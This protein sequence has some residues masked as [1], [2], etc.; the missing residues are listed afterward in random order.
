MVTRKGLSE[1]AAAGRPEGL[2]KGA[3]QKLGKN[4]LDR[5]RA[6]WAAVCEGQRRW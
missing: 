5:N 6:T 1:K 3:R 2:R 4:L